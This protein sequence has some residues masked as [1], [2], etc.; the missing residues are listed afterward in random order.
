MAMR[1][2][3]DAPEFADLLR[4]F[5][6]RRRRTRGR[7]LAYP[8]YVVVLVL[9]IYAG[10]PIA[11]AIESLGHTYRPD[12]TTFRIEA[13]A[14]YGLIGMALL[15]LMALSR[16][17]LWRGPVVMSQADAAWLLPLPI[18]R[19]RLMLPRYFTSAVLS[20]LVAVFLGA[21]S[22]VVLHAY[23]LGTIAR[24][25]PE[26]L[27]YAVGLALIG[28]GGAAVV[29]QMPA[30]AGVVRRSRG[31]IILVAAVFAVLAARAASGPARS[32]APA[33][34]HSFGLLARVA[35]GVVALAVAAYGAWL[36][37]RVSSIA[38]RQR[39]AVGS[40]MSTAMY[41]VDLRRARLAVNSATHGRRRGPRLRP[42]RRS[43]LSVPWRDIGSV[44]SAPGGFGWAAAWIALGSAAFAIAAR[45]RVDGRHEIFPLAVS[46]LCG[47][48]AAVPY[49]ES[50][51]V[52]AD[53]WR[54]V[55]W[56]PYPVRSLAA[57]HA[58]VPAVLATV[59]QL[60]AVAVASWWLSGQE[61]VIAVAVALATG[62]VLAVAAMISAFRGPLP[63]QLIFAQ[64]DLG[65]VL[66]I[67]WYLLGPLSAILLG[68]LAALPV[69]HAFHAGSSSAG[70]AIGTLVLGAVATS[71]LVAW[72][73]D[74]AHRRFEA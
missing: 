47:H 56:S 64:P 43:A 12:P 34:T 54:R 33:I 18:S 68:G 29:E 57:R 28:L 55:R 52:D 48:V 59:G 35:V 42:P 14:P 58:V 65:P 49:T 50:T 22:A 1:M 60:I 51:R 31:P 5:R 27:V 16:Q 10:P 73:R 38:L 20:V 30:A 72:A 13:A 9:L 62:P 66:F 74:R 53:D 46:M 25:L 63:L 24:L 7:K 19:R 2:P 11:R 61:V 71:A 36:A 15:V 3:T 44:L 21:I 39:A 70:A 37:P 40:A 17:A 4:Q 6:Q 26:S 8:V 23:A 32:S 69:L 41:V 45:Q 67:F